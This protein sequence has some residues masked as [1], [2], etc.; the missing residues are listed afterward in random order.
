VTSCVAQAS[1][2]VQPGN[3][4]IVAATYDNLTVSVTGISDP[5]G[6]TFSEAIAPLQ[7]VSSAYHTTVWTGVH[8]AGAGTVPVTVQLS[9]ASLVFF[10]VYVTEYANVTGIDQRA[11]TTAFAAS[12]S[13]GFR[14]T[15][16]PDEVV[17]GHG[18]AMGP[19]VSVGSGFTTRLLANNNAE[20]DLRVAAIGSY[21]ASFGL[22][23]SGEFIA[24]MLTLH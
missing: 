13:S 22:S 24:M 10:D 9:G 17:W 8:T 11:S 19:A 5:D 16:F 14:T 3:L 15:M 23:S 18:E 7:W 20:E 1:G 12:S 21:D 4:L 2:L 6:D